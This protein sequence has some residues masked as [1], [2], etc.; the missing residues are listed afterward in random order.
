M[1]KEKFNAFGEKI[2]AWPGKMWDK[3]KLGFD[4]LVDK[5]KGLGKMIKAY[6]AYPFNVE[7]KRASGDWLPSSTI[8]DGKV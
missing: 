1:V 8:L 4:G 7:I 3:L 6:M 2:K 5:I